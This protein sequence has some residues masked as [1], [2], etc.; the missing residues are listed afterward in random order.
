MK[1]LVTT[2]LCVPSYFNAGHRLALYEVGGYLQRKGHIAVT[3]DIASLNSTWKD[4]V[5][6]LIQNKF[7]VVAI[8]NDF[9]LIEGF[10]RFT[11]YIKEF[12]PNTK[13]ITFGRLSSACADIFQ[14]FKIDAIV[15][16]GD[17][18]PGVDNFIN[19]LNDGILPDGVQVFSLNKWI[20]PNKTGVFLP[21]KDW[22]LP[23]VSEIIYKAYDA[24]YSTDQRKFCGIPERRELVVPVS[25]G[26]PLG[27]NFCEV[28][29]R[30]GL[31]ERRLPVSI[32]VDYIEESFKHEPF[33]YVSM[34][35]PTFTL[36]K[37]WIYDFCNELI[38]RGNKYPW[39][40]TTT[41]FHLDEQMVKLMG[42]SKCFRISVGVESLEDSGLENLPN[43]KH[44]IKEHLDELLKWCDEANIELNCFVIVGLPNTTVNGT[45]SM[46]DYLRSKKAHIRPS[47][48]SDYSLLDPKM[49]EHEILKVLGRHILPV[50]T[51]F[52]LHERQQLYQLVFGIETSPTRV[53]DSIPKNKSPS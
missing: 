29:P 42:Q 52:S 11:E 33:E 38:K 45:I 32:T 44:N 37:K 21:T 2:P 31:K 25:R 12:S 49:N 24:L 53:M 43:H 16:T 5:D 4:L 26:C 20:L 19:Y 6:L 36:K 13:I 14:Q 47:I 51:N 15:A 22:V 17:Y 48:F 46:F 9:D 50:T 10:A 39:K 30:E 34:Y 7:D 35:S 23:N 40:C 1:V 41:I 18:E 8:M 28:W 27:C 3:T